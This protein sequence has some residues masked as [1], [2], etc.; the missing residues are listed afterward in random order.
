MWQW[1]INFLFNINMTQ[2]KIWTYIKLWFWITNGRLNWAPKKNFITIFVGINDHTNDILTQRLTKILSLPFASL[3][4]T[5]TNILHSR[6][7]LQEADEHCH[8]TCHGILKQFTIELEKKGKSKCLLTKE[9]STRDCQ[10]IS[11]KTLQW[12]N[13]SKDD[14]NFF[15]FSSMIKSVFMYLFSNFILHLRTCIRKDIYFLGNLPKKNKHEKKEE[16]Q[17]FI[18]VHRTWIKRNLL[19]LIERKHSTVFL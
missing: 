7:I 11:S 9:T 13:Y 16:F 10:N 18:K 8:I 6:D 4:R 12:T 14:K 17:Y 2:E 1:N 3:E 19:K 15:S 5:F